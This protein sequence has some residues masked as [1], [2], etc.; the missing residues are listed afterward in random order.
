MLSDANQLPAF[1]PRGVV[2]LLAPL[3]LHLASPEE[4]EL[5]RR[6]A[7]ELISP[8]I[9]LTE[10]LLRV[11]ERCGA[12][13][14]VQRVANDVTGVTTLLPLRPEGLQAIKAHAFD[15]RLPPNELLCAPGDPLAATYLWGFAATT[16][17]ASAAVV[18]MT[19]RLREHWSEIPFFTRAV[20][21][22]GSKVVRGRMG[23]R[24]YPNAP[25][26][27]LWNPVSSLQERAA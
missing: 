6:L 7:A 9:A 22:A 10:T 12:A 16:K 17:R 1:Q 8:A 19:I 21:R 26:D 18:H 25:D 11:Q 20:T 5:G 13:V 27:L 14:F 15:T 23:Y 3:D 24:P 2:G 4:C